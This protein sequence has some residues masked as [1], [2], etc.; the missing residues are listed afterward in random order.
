MVETSARRS[1]G[2][3]YANVRH[4]HRYQRPEQRWNHHSASS[5][6]RYVQR[7]FQRQSHAQWLYRNASHPLSRQHQQA[8]V[9]GQDSS[10]ASGSW[11]RQTAVPPYTN[12]SILGNYLVPRRRRYSRLLDAVIFCSRTETAISN[13]I[14][15][16]AA[17]RHRHT[18][19]FRDLRSG[20]DRQGGHDGSS[21]GNSVRRVG[22][23]NRSAPHRQC[24]ALSSFNLGL[25]N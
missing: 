8:F 6:A 15:N 9:V 14:Q 10:V 3:L 7:C 22:E 11:S 20:L 21:R 16:S 17:H 4:S 5:L 18:G 13:G 24:P 23:E 25:T 12:L 2:I 19:S 1:P